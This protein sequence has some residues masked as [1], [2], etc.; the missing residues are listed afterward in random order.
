VQ[1]P[2]KIE[3]VFT[4]VAKQWGSID[5]LVQC[6]AFA[7]KEELTGDYSAIS[8][9]GFGRALEVS[10][11]SLTPLC[12]F[13]KP[14]FTDGASM[15]TLSYLAPSGPSRTTTWPRPPSALSSVPPSGVN[16]EGQHRRSRCWQFAAQIPCVAM[17][18][19]PTNPGWAGL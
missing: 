1:N 5:V 11:Y 8:P 18:G 17:G 15:I 7:G 12:R 9:E 14:L 16:P 6:L 3:A 13:A 19:V 10:A 4:R 2:A